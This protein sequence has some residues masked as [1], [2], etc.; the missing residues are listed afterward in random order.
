MLAPYFFIKQGYRFPRRISVPYFFS[1]APPRIAQERRLGFKSVV[2]PVKRLNALRAAYGLLSRFVK[3]G[4]FAMTV[5]IAMPQPIAANFHCASAILTEALPAG[6]IASDS[7]V[8]Y[9][10]NHFEKTK[11]LVC[12]VVLDLELGA[13]ARFSFVAAEAVREYRYDISALAFA[14]PLRFAWFCF[15]VFLYHCQFSECSAFQ[16]NEGR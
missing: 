5:W 9:R 14:D 6:F 13:T 11:G 2:S 1:F 3:S 8:L 7:C 15:W 12:K 4:A 10:L 16:I